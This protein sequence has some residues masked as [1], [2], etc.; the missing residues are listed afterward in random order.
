MTQRSG[1]TRLAAT[2]AVIGLL[3]GVVVGRWFTPE[4]AVEEAVEEAAVLLDGETAR[5]LALDGRMVRWAEAVVVELNT[6]LRFRQLG[7]GVQGW[8]EPRMEDVAFA[9][10]RFDGW[11]QVLVSAAMESVVRRRDDASVAR[12]L[13]EA[14]L[15]RDCYSR[16]H[17]RYSLSIRAV[18][19]GTG[20]LIARSD[21]IGR[22]MLCPP[23][24]SQCR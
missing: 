18:A 9:G 13:L 24:V 19:E 15:F 17:E 2:A 11:G 6:C 5:P 14:A 12:W 4:P 1:R 8:I 16:E 21:S 7:G 22:V 3:V 23:T 10:L 20:R